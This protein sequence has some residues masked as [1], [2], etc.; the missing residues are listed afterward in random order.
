MAAFLNEMKTVRL[1]KVSASEKRSTSLGSDTSFASASNISIGDEPS[2]SLFRKSF[3]SLNQVTDAL[4]GSRHVVASGNHSMSEIETRRGEKRKRTIT[5]SQEE[6][7][8]FVTLCLFLINLP[9]IH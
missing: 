6:L 5:G 7:R 8:K 2:S 9:V 3:S 4:R 1:R